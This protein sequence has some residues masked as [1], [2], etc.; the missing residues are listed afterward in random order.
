MLHILNHDFCFDVNS[1]HH[2]GNNMNGHPAL[3]LELHKVR[4]IIVD[5]VLLFYRM[6]LI[7]LLRQP[8]TDS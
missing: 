5:N 3:Y 7:G 2:L 4:Q 6:K 1:Q 8:T